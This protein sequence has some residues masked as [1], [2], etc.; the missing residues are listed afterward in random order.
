ILQKF[1][2]GSIGP[3]HAEPTKTVGTQE[4]P[5]VS[6][7]GNGK[8][9]KTNGGSS[10]PGDK[11][12]KEHPGHTPLTV[13]GLHGRQRQL[14]RNNSLGLHFNYLEVHGSSMI[15]ELDTSGTLTFNTRHV[16]FEECEPN[17]NVLMRF[18]EHIALNALL[19]ETIPSDWKKDDHRQ[20]FNDSLPYFVYLLLHADEIIAQR[21]KTKDKK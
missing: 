2:V 21:Q 9:E 18:Q 12:K 3:G 10:S 13:G 20:M 8:K 1:K 16:L 15:W 4:F 6:I 5:S 19:L 11:T 7:H 17:D 14:V